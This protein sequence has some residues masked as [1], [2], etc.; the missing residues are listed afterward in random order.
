MTIERGA[1]W[2]RRVA[3]PADLVTV[4]GDALLAA[5]LARHDARPVTVRSGDLARTLGV[6][7]GR[8]GAHGEAGERTV[9]ELPIDLIEVRLGDRDDIQMACAHVIAR[10]PWNGGGGWRGPI[11]AVMNAEFY[12]AWDVAPRGHPNDGRVEVI[13]IDTSMSIRQRLTARR[14]A[15]TGTHL[16]HPMITSRSV[17]TANWSFPRPLA[18]FIDGRPAGRTTSLTIEVR[19]DA[20][21]VYV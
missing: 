16:P 10:A 3:A 18:V 14:R 11:V 21:V 12:G 6:T 20:G 9:N 7:S 19:A 2:G 4:G 1:P 13:E 17:R 8:P 15:L 5:E